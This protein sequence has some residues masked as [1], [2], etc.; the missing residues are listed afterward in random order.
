MP[1]MI[2]A[3]YPVCHIQRITSEEPDPDTGND[4]VV[5]L[6]PV[7]RYAQGISQI[8]RMRGSSKFVLTPE[9]AKRVDTEL[10]ISVADPSVYGPLDQVL[11]FPEIDEYGDY[12]PGSGFAFWVDAL[13]FDGRQGPWPLFLK[14]FGG[15]VRLRRAT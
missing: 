14:A 5:D 9:F 11:L 3:P 7:I 4:V 10:H 8:G 1:S 2:P 12:V 6:P 13:P 15:M